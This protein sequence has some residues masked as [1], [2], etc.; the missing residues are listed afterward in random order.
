MT[1]RRLL[2][3]AAALL[4]AATRCAEVQ[5]ASGQDICDE[6]GFAV[7]N[8]TLACSGDQGLSNARYEKLRADYL[9]T[10]AE[11]TSDRDAQVDCPRSLLALSCDQVNA[12]GDDLDRWLRDIVPCSTLFARKDGKSMQPPDPCLPLTSCG[13]VCVDINSNP[14]HCGGCGAVCPSAQRN[15]INRECN[16]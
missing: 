15:C 13:G 1:A 8:R 5:Q 12:A 2:L 7:S 11:P 14:D 16:F 4:L 10:A 9:C 3:S 6:A